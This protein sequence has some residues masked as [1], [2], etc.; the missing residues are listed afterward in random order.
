MSQKPKIQPEKTKE[1][2]ERT[3]ERNL[4]IGAMK[5]Q[6]PSTVDSLAMAINIEKSLIVKHLIAMRQFG[7]IQVVGEKDHQLV[8]SLPEE[9]KPKSSS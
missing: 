7:K 6:G 3:K 9:H 5:K 2:Q 4:I 8:Y 1:M